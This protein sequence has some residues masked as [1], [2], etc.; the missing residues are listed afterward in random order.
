MEFP[1]PTAPFVV[2]LLVGTVKKPKLTNVTTGMF[3]GCSMIFHTQEGEKYV[4]EKY[5]KYSRTRRLHSTRDVSL[6]Y[7]S[8]RT[9]TRSSY[10]TLF[11]NRQY[12][13]TQ[14]YWPVRKTNR[15]RYRKPRRRRWTSFRRRTSLKLAFKISPFTFIF[16]F[17]RKKIKSYSKLYI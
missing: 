17:I 16:R 12:K 5:I 2:A 9:P 11:Q 14:C 13:R 4:E 1:A 8:G 3:T 7:A 6:Q 10:L 15:R